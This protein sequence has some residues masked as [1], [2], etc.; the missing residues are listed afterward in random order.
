MLKLN[1]QFSAFLHTKGITAKFKLEF[2]NMGESARKQHAVDVARSN[3]M[4][5]TQPAVTKVS[6]ATLCSG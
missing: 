4:G 1:E 3:A 5:K 6:A 2:H